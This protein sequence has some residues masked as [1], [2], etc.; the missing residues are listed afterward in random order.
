VSVAPTSPAYQQVAETIRSQILAGQLVPGNR[1]PVEGELAE[2]YGVSRSTV[3]EALR[4][5]A[6]QGLV[7][8]T[9]GVTGGTFVARPQPEQVSESLVTGI[10]FLTGAAELSVAELLEAR[11]LL[12]VPAAGMAAARRSEDQLAAL[13]SALPDRPGTDL[14]PT[15]E[16][17]R[18]FHVLVL[19]AANNRL[20]EVMTRPVFEI[21]QTRF[22]R[23]QAPRTFW[24]RV[25]TE[26][27][28]IFDAIESGDRISAEQRMLD[29]L[30]HLR[31]TY[32][33]IDKA[34][35]P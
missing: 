19:E 28:S 24:K 23:D 8:T 4:S 12:E 7:V 10:G 3:R 9:R 22:L 31:R 29:H 34:A 25:D 27:R 11:E 6:S 2:A 33:R 20:V 13:R 14:S 30:H 5:L 21:L 26:H 16:S 32:E 35:R 1:L 15:F 18:N 17:N